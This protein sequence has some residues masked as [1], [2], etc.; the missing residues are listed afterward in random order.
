MTHNNLNKILVGLELLKHQCNKQQL[1]S[2]IHLNLIVILVVLVNL[3][4]NLVHKWN[5][6]MNFLVLIKQKVS[7][8]QLK[9]Q[10]NN[11]NNKNSSH[12]KRKNRK[13]IMLNYK[14]NNNSLKMIKLYCKINNRLKKTQFKKYKLSLIKL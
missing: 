5:G 2:K 7:N 14:L 1:H 13:M 9:K 11:L 8:N 4:N 12:K 3:S 6:E 10:R